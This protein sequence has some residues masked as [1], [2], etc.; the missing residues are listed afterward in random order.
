MDWTDEMS[1]RFKKKN[2]DKY[3]GIVMNF[4]CY[5][6]TYDTISQV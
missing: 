2:R 4:N 5:S 1:A 6:D 3:F